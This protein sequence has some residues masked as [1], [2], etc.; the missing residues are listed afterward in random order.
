MNKYRRMPSHTVIGYITNCSDNV[1]YDIWFDWKSDISDK[2]S[3]VHTESFTY[4]DVNVNGVKYSENVG[5]IPSNTVNTGTS[6]RC[7][8]K[9]IDAVKSTD[10]ILEEV[11]TLIHYNDGWVRCVISDIDIYNRLLV[12]IWDIDKTYCI[13]DILLNRYPNFFKLYPTNIPGSHSGS[14]S[15]RMNRGHSS[16]SSWR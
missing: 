10:E 9:K 4:V 13:N 14:H 2:Y 12:E 16:D 5:I 8:L 6:Y 7:R 3:A 11:E 15:G 1:N